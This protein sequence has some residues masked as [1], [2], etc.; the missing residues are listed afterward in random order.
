MVSLGVVLGFVACVRSDMY[1]LPM[2]HQLPTCARGCARWRHLEA[3]G[4]LQPQTAADRMW[5]DGPP[6]GAGCAM[7]GRA[8]QC[9][10][11]FNASLTGTWPNCHPVG[12]SR[13]VGVAGVLPGPPSGEEGFG[14]EFSDKSGLRASPLCYPQ[15]PSDKGLFS[16]GFDGAFCFCKDAQQGPLWQ[17]CASPPSVPEQIN[18][19]LASPTSVV[20]SFVTFNDAGSVSAPPA[21]RYAPAASARSDA[22]RTV[23]GVTHV[24]GMNATGMKFWLKFGD[25]LGIFWAYFGQATTR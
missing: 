11:M 14:V 3:D 18:L 20:V 5:V 10:N 9:C 13:A 23:R 24:Y 21:V 22:Q 12:A 1:D 8:V 15:F 25:I 2:P 17:Y 19:Q 7:P 6:A 4:N 16:P